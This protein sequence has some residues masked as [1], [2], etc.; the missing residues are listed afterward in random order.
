[1]SLVNLDR[2]IRLPTAEVEALIQ[3]QMIAAM[4]WRS[5]NPGEQFALYPADTSINLLPAEQYYR[6]PFLPIAQTSFSELSSETVSIKA[7]VRCEQGQML[8]EPEKLKA[9]SQLTIW[10]TEAL[11][12]PLLSRPFIFLAYLR[13][14][15]LSQPFE[16]PVH[17]SGNFVSLPKSL[18]VTDSTP[19]L[20]ES[21][22]AKRCK[23]LEKLEPPEH[24][25]LE[26]LQSALVD[27]S[28]TNP[29]AKQLDAQL[30]TFLGWSEKSPTTKLY[31]D[32][33]WI[34]AIAALGN[35]TKELD[36]NISNY[37]AGTD[38]EN[39]VRDSLEFLGFTIDYAHKGGAGG[40][41]LFCSKPY[42]LVGECKAG[43]KIP[44]DT[45]VQLLNLGT[46]RLK[47]AE[48]LK[49][50][51]KLI[52]GPGEPTRQLNDAAKL[53]GMAI[54][55]PETLEKLV[56]LHSNYPNSVDLFKLKEYLKPG[57]SDDE[58][59]KYI[60]KVEQEIKVRSHVL[61]ILKKYLETTG[62]ERAS[63]DALSGAYSMSNPPKH[64]SREELHEILVELSSPL[65]GY[66]GRIKGDSLGRDRFYF[67]R[68]LRLDD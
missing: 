45:A 5:F 6:S 23:K 62:S 17:P 31:S 36:T 47:D 28:T 58:V 67:L 54:M 22:F 63:V 61:S 39:V 46:L 37:Q 15:L 11:L 32:L 3:G 33:G 29:K 12:Q 34:S 2:A 51:T 1:M 66:A 19:V 40:L 30:K 57:Q 50:A 48:M 14:Y 53:H 8:N 7:W 42:P 27:L 68:D 26:E 55:N 59:A 20:S 24:P 60:E 44:N 18:T 13:V 41:D 9:L 10:T 25:E 49:K 38:F 64:L 4:T 43:K 52:I 16:I 56:K 35:R 65:T 21:M